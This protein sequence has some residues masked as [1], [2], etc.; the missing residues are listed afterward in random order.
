MGSRT[1]GWRDNEGC[2][3]NDRERGRDRGKEGR[4]AAQWDGERTR[5]MGSG[6]EKLRK[7]IQ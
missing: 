3:D 1:E 7:K 4:G 5:G 6:A 2:K